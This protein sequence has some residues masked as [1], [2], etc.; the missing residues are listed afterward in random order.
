MTLVQGV[1]SVLLSLAIALI[2]AG[3][4]A[5]PLHK[6]A[7]V[8][9]LIASIVTVLYLW[10]HF[11]KMYIPGIQIWLAMLQK[12]WLSC[13]LLAIVMFTGCFDAHSPIRRHLQPIR[14]E[15]S[16]LSFILMNAHAWYYLPIYLPNFFAY[17]SRDGWLGTSLVVSIVLT[18]LYVPL[19]ITSIKYLRTHMSAKSW[20]HLQ[21][22]AYVLVALLYLHIIFV[23][24]RPLFQ[25][26]AISQGHAISLVVYTS[27][28]VLYAI[29]RL[30]KWQRDRKATASIT[31]A[32]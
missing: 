20:K 32:S 27:L 13:W 31:A 28:G 26:S 21:R 8:F 3:P 29:M 6:H 15:L 11:S 5:K 16:I 9:Y 18:L 23:L 1:I 19:T 25:G 24:A 4:L 12:G 30:A 2:I 14:A 7:W 17:L 22:W 10:Y